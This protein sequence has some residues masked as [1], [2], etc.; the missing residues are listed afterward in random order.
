MVIPVNAASTRAPWSSL[1]PEAKRRRLV[2]AAET[3]FA[4]DGLDAPV[5]AIAT[6]AGA[7]VGSVYRAFASK[8]DLIAALALERLS[9]FTHEAEAALDEP[10]AGK[11]LES[12]LRAVVARDARD[13]VLSSALE[14]AFERPDVAPSR[15]AA[16]LAC[17]RLLDRAA[18]QG[19]FRADLTPDDIR[20]LLVGIRAAGRVSPGSGERLL[21][22][23]L[24]G[25]RA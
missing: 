9:W 12:L 3:V 5:P 21:E 1:D 23:A 17:Q 11:A 19:S 4:R 24:S 2:E 16:V 10:D 25:L 22:L 6:E 20:L 15:A 13:R 7:G 14:T 18:G 8:D